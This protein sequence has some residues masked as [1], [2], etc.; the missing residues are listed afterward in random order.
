[1]TEAARLT[2]YRQ[3][4]NGSRLERM[5]RAA[6][7]GAGSMVVGTHRGTA[8]ADSSGPKEKPRRLESRRG[9]AI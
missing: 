7:V 9:A 8:S 4:R 1:M 6:G 5:E 2:E 3:T